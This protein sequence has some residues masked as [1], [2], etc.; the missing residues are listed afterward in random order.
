MRW[1]II[2]VLL[3]LPSKVYGQESEPL[4][5]QEEEGTPPCHN[6]TDQT[7]VDKEDLK[8]FLQLARERKCLDDNPPT[9]KVDPI[10]IITD[11]DG[12]VFYTGNDPEHPYKLEMSWCHYD[13]KGEGEVKVLAAMKE[14]P[15]WGFRFRPKAYMGYMPV[16]PFI[17]KDFYAGLDA[18][19]M[20]DLLYYRWFNLNVAAGF[21]STGLG[22]GVDITKNFG[23]YVGYAFSYDLKPVNN[24]MVAFYFAF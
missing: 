13:V 14:P 1:F 24:V 20:L 7:C 11:E 8:K 21:R 22:V 23:G 12:R 15:I 18:G 6:T 17:E 19:V 10:T 4:V 2:L 5:I 16:K 3:L 9:F